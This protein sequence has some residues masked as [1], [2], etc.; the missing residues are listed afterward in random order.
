M[1]RVI[2]HVMNDDPFVAEID[3]LPDPR[4]SY[5]VLRNPRRRDGKRLPT[6]ADGVTTILYPW[7]RIT[8]IELLDT[9]RSPAGE[10]LLTIFRDDPATSR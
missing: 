7:H 4:D 6:I 10:E 5:L 8:F 3:D 2:V 1:L 9:E